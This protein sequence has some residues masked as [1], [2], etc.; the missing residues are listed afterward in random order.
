M[1]PKI[2][3]EEEESRESF[4]PMLSE[5]YYCNYRVFRLCLHFPRPLNVV[6]LALATAIACLSVSWSRG[7]DRDALT[8]AIMSFDCHSWSPERCSFTITSERRLDRDVEP[9]LISV[10]HETSI[11][12]HGYEYFLCVSG[13][14]YVHM[15]CYLSCFSEKNRKSIMKNAL[16]SLLQ[17][18]VTEFHDYVMQAGFTFSIPCTTTIESKIRLT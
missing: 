18:F 4:L 13:V 5:V 7:R 8:H 9:S 1:P 3:A 17:T 14:L 16:S 10:P 11:C 6:C 2:T 15:T 12:T